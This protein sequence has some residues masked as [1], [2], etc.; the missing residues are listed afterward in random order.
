MVSKLKNIFSKGSKAKAKAKPE[1]DPDPKPSYTKL[2][3]SSDSI[4]SA[5]STDAAEAKRK[6]WE[7]KMEKEAE[8]WLWNQGF[9]S[10]LPSFKTMTPVDDH[11]C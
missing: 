8:D 11:E 5:K 6:A 3:D 9:V 2:Q 4:C 1:P 7:A 10:R